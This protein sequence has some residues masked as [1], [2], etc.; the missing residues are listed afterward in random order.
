MAPVGGQV[1]AGETP[2]E[3]A[4]RE[5]IEEMGLEAGKMIPL[6]SYRVDVNRGFGTISCFLAMDSKPSS[7]QLPSDELEDQ[8]LVAL[9][10]KDLFKAV[11]S[12]SLQEVKWAGS[13]AMAI[14][15]MIDEE[16][17]P[18]TYSKNVK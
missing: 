13:L 3:A 8:H 18:K 14:V 6:G 1:E 17:I 4:N 15:N 10:W 7:V 2:E 11:R 5:L 9:D 12:G 16:S